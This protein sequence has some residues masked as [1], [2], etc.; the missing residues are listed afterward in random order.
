MKVGSI[1]CK[2]LNGKYILMDMQLAVKGGW[3]KGGGGKRL[4]SRTPPFQ[5]LV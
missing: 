1:V 2:L 4:K 3:R 5:S